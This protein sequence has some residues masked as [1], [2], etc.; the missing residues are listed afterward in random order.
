MTAPLL[1]LI[2]IQTRD[3]WSR[4]FAV[5]LSVGVSMM[6]WDQYQSERVNVCSLLCVLLLIVFCYCV[7]A[8]GDRTAEREGANV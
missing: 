2:A 5:L 6:F 3:R 7:S 4:F 8:G 1:M